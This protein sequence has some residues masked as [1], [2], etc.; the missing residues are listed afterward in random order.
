MRVLVTGSAGFVGRHIIRKLAER[1][2][3]A[4]G[5]DIREADAAKRVD[6][7]HGRA[8]D[9]A[10]GRIGPECV[11]HLAAFIS[12]PES[13]AKPLKYI[14]NNTVG[15]VNALESSR[16]FGIRKIVYFSSAAVYG[17]PSEYPLRE[18]SPVGPVNPYGASKLMSEKAVEGYSSSYGLSYIIFRPSN[19]YG[20]GQNP[21]YAG[22]MHAF[23][24]A[25]AGG[26]NPVIF[27]DGNQTRDFIHVND[28]AEAVVSALEGE[29]RNLVMNLSSGKSTTVNFLA[30]MFKRAYGK[31]INFIYG[32]PREGDI[33]RSELSNEL[34]IR[35]LK[36]SP[37]VNLQDG[38][39]EIIG[40][41]LNG[42]R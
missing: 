39:R 37:Q 17:E 2:H 15:T 3:S 18:S 24:S 12:P 29:A 31:D 35:A 38:L 42:Q 4:F 40:W 1:G 20:I 10:F 23:A 14:G 32:P 9:E 28:V 34:I 41:Y 6:V 30:E 11:V 21:E 19:I 22:V 33:Y 8:L 27:G 26:K 16:K 7:R 25:I 5:I 36:W 13:M